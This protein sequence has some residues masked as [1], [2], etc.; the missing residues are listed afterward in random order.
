M[1][2]QSSLSLVL[3]L[4]LASCGSPYR[5]PVD[6]SGEPLFLNAGRQHLVNEGETL[7]VVAWMYDLDFAALARA[8]NLQE[9][10]TLTPGQKLAVDLRGYSS[11]TKAGSAM[12][13]APGAVA[14]DGE[15]VAVAKPAGNIGGLRRSQLPDTGGTAQTSR[16]ALPA[17]DDV[18]TGNQQVAA[19]AT[20]NKAGLEV[21][22]TIPATTPSAAGVP[23]T[24]GASA[25]S[26]VVAAFSG[27]GDV[28]WGWPYRGTVVGRFSEDG[29]NS[30]G[31]DI[32]GKEGDPVLAAA[33]GEVVYAGSGLL[34]YGNLLIIKH[35]DR[36]LSAYAHNRALLVGEKT[37]VSKGQKIAELGSSGIDK[38]MLHFEIRV[39]GKPSDP[40]AYLPSLK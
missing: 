25:G 28:S 33:D 31:I 9:P 8:N 32:A 13:A 37:K 27:T 38:N 15:A 7:Y 18:A 14:N 19:P 10:Y 21:P 12:A 35:N 34:R 23:T 6:Q 39:D 29:A 20:V 16:S 11:K 22:K 30:K 24:P 4:L 1:R 2:Y 40:M 5:P 36:F 26:K 3:A 17:A